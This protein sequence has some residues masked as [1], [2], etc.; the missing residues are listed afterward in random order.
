M[1]KFNNNQMVPIQYQVIDV[2]RSYGISESTIIELIENALDEILEHKYR[3]IAHLYIIIDM[4]YDKSKCWSSKELIKYNTKKWV[5]SL[6]YVDKETIASSAKSYIQENLNCWTID[7]TKYDKNKLQDI[8]KFLRL[9]LG[10]NQNL[11]CS[12]IIEIEKIVETTTKLNLQDFKVSYSDYKNTSNGPTSISGGSKMMNKLHN[13]NRYQEKSLP[14]LK[15][16]VEFF[17]Y[18]STELEIIPE[19]KNICQQFWSLYKSSKTLNCNSVKLRSKNVHY[20]YIIK[21]VTGLP[22]F[23]LTEAIMKSEYYSDKV[24]IE[25][26]CDLSNG[27]LHKTL[28]MSFDNFFHKTSNSCFLHYK[29]DHEENKRLKIKYEKEIIE[30][31]FKGNDELLKRVNMLINLKITDYI[32][33]Q[34]NL[35][36]LIKKEGIKI[37]KKDVTKF[38]KRYY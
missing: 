30:E 2:L 18:M 20:L 17:N 32:T 21:L 19:Q 12:N 8:I 33:C 10:S 11:N 15:E 29:R 28:E 6:Y 25:L 3:I 22:H 37:T 9:T 5:I 36:K 13:T 26:L 38:I 23:S 4:Y 35:Y 34:N 14:N 27:K 1:Q 31:S 24:N 16:E 7:F